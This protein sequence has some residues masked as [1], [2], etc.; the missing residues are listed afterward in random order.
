VNLGFHDDG[1]TE[2]LRNLAGFGGG[3]R[4]VPLGRGDSVT[5]KNRFR[6]VL[7]DFH[8]GEKFLMLTCRFIQRNSKL[9]LMSS[10]MRV[11][12]SSVGTK[13]LIGVTGVALF[14]YLIIHVSA[15]VLVFFGPEVFNGVAE[16]LEQIPLLPVIE[17]GLLLVFLTHV[18]KTVDMFLE[19]RRARPVGYAVKTT[20]GPPS[21]KSFASS[22][23]ILSGVWLLAFIVIHVKAFKFSP[24]YVWGDGAKD[25]YR[26]EM[27]NFRNPFIAGFYVLS[28]LVVGS[29]LWHGVS[30]AFQ[31][32]GVEQ[33]R[34]SH[35]LLIAGRALAVVIAG[36]FIAITVWAYM[37]ASRA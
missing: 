23:M 12:A 16:R 22:T 1:P 4:D 5:R 28:M 34:G 20:A 15:N 8:S 33:R 13:L 14:L 30:S 32:L 36:A 37:S 18:V 35:G 31:S 27:D 10:R 25:F 2:F 6:L 29:H 9:A 7:V 3:Q 24:T 11:L 26:L 19:N 17:I 21:R